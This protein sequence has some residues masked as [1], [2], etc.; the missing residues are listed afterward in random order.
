MKRS[1]LRE[2]WE[3][4][5]TNDNDPHVAYRR[6]PPVQK[7]MKLR[8]KP[9]LEIETYRKMFDFRRDSTHIL[10]LLQEMW[11]REDHKKKV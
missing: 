3:K 4:P 2:F 9:K 8:E 11:V 6:R 10:L 7:K 5:D 1:F